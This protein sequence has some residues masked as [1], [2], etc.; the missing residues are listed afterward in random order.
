MSLF[1]LYENNSIK[2][3][4]WPFSREF[5]NTHQVIK[6]GLNSQLW[7]PGAPTAVIFGKD[8]DAAPSRLH[9]PPMLRAWVSRN[10]NCTLCKST[11]KSEYRDLARKSSSKDNIR[12]NR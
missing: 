12:W 7:N 6:V 4:N 3:S 11:G 10:I 1:S 8:Q 9:P 2:I 5:L